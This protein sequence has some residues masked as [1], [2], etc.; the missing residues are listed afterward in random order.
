M[1]GRSIGGRLGLL[2]GVGF[3]P[4]ECGGEGPA[5]EP[6]MALGS[7]RLGATIGG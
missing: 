5:G 7:R 1:A 4:R 6:L 3:L 2:G